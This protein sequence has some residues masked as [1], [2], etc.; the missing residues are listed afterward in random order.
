MGTGIKFR[1]PICTVDVC[2]LGFAF[3]RLATRMDGST[4][5]ILLESFYLNHSIRIIPTEASHSKPSTRIIAVESFESVQQKGN[6]RSE[7]ARLKREAIRLLEG[8]HWLPLASIALNRE[9]DLSPLIGTRVRCSP[10][11]MVMVTLLMHSNVIR[12]RTWCINI[13][14][15]R[16][17]IYSAMLAIETRRFEGPNCRT[18][19]SCSLPRLF[20]H[21]RYP[22][23]PH[24]KI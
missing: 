8:F 13:S 20:R 6:A 16:W 2:P 21:K 19:S 12:C 18:E 4:W 17:A 7:K 23:N 1:P 24:Y 9:L 3:E 22:S 15:Y 5:T 10:L 11:L 14:E